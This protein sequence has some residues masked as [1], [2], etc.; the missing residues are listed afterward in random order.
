MLAL[1][2]APALLRAVPPTEMR[3]V[4]TT[5]LLGCKAP[6]TRCVETV[7]TPVPRPTAGQVLVQVA[8]SSVNPSDV[9]TVQLGGC[10]KGCGN[11]FAGTVAACAP[12]GCGR[13][14]VG[15]PVW[16]CAEPSFSEFVTAPES[17]T[18]LR[19]ATLG[20]AAAAT[21]PEVGLTSLNGLKRSLHWKS[22][23][24]AYNQQSAGTTLLCTG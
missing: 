24:S 5:S 2:L 6:F 19:P 8:G 13:L 11:D 21:L 1:L 22:S 20:A 18:S 9:D 17:H 23:S 12:G 15:D 10:G 16:G 7:T 4:R 3:Q 14:K